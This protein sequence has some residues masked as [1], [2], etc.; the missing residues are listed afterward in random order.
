LVGGQ[1]SFASAVGLFKSLIGFI[2][3]VVSYRLA[4]KFAN[5]RI[6]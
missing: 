2:L 3:V 6:F 5:Y 1:F 4:Y